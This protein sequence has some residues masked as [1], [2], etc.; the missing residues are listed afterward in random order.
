[1]T[2]HIP[3]PSA[4]GSVV[5]DLGA[6]IGALVLDTPCDMAGREIEISLNGF[7]DAP[8]THSRVRARRAGPG[9]AFA[10]VYPGLPAGDYTI[11]RDPHTPAA[12]ATI[13]GGQVTRLALPPEPAAERRHRGG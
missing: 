10:A 12:M 11:W 4:A 9:S 6:D 2:E 7:V 3:G 8:R 1:M 13:I 5:L